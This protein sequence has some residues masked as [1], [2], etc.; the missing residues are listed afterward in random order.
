MR[1]EQLRVAS[2]LVVVSCTLAACEFQRAQVA[3]DAKKGLI[4]MPK[5]S[6]LQCMGSPVTTAYAGST[7]V[8]TYQSGNNRTD[9]FGSV[10]GWVGPGGYMNGFGSST[11]TTRSCKIDLVMQG[12][13]VSRVNYSGDTGGLITKGEQCGFAV[14][15]CVEELKASPTEPTAFTP[16]PAPSQTAQSNDAP[17]RLPHCAKEE[18]ATAKLAKQQGY[19]YSLGCQP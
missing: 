13:F 1:G 12:G 4:G 11:S 2:L 14:E 3:S 15:N 10:S 6:I 5:E 19:N 17:A 8:W 18:L 7:E 16:A 9:S